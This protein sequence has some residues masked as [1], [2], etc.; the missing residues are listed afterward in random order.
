MR[1]VILVV[2]FLCSLSSA[3]P[4]P[5]AKP[6]AQLDYAYGDYGDYAYGDYGE[7]GP[8]Q[9]AKRATDVVLCLMLS[10]TCHFTYGFII[11]PTHVSPI[12]CPS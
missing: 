2:G 8:G 1:V 6:K 11:T 7:Y 4:K 5:K 9:L 3:E 10:R 12:D